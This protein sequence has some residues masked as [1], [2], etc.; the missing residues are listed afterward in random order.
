[1]SAISVNG[2]AAEIV[3]LETAALERRSPARGAADQAVAKRSAQPQV[4]RHE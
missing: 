4:R 2:A 3:A 1:M